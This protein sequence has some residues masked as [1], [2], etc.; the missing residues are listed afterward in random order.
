MT[1]ETHTSPTPMAAIDDKI[2]ANRAVDIIPASAIPK[3]ADGYLP[4][5]PEDRR[6]LRRVDAELIPEFIVALLALVK[7]G[8]SIQEDLGKKA[9][10]AQENAR[11]HNKLVALR[12]TLRVSRAL[13]AY[14]E[15]LE[16]IA[17]ND[18]ILIL[19][20]IKRL[21]E[22]NVEDA[23]LAAVYADVLE[24]FQARGNKVSEG[25]ASKKAEA[26]P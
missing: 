21:Y 14:L 19:E 8:D 1:D 23:N 5:T 9:P 15:E 2:A 13:V 20:R 25:I 12:E 11:V 6:Y 17:I 7:R 4:T 24:F 22:N 3:I 18:G 26:K 16:D 10:S